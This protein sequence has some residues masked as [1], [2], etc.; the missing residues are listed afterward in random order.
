MGVMKSFFVA[1]RH[2]GGGILN[3]AL[4][5]SCMACG[6]ET[7]QAGL[8]CSAC[9]SKITFISDPCCDACGVPLTATG[10]A[11]R[12]LCTDCE[13]EH[14]V[15]RR[16]RGAFIYDDF[17]RRLILGLK[18]QDRT[19]NA[20]F[21]ATQMRRAG[22]ELLLNAD[23]IVPVPLHRS[24]LWHRR[25]NQAALLAKHL[26]R[27][28]RNLNFKADILKRARNTRSLASMP[29]R[30]RA[31]M[32]KEA[33]LVPTQHRQAVEGRRIVLIDDVLTTGATAGMCA[34]VLL[35]AGAASVD[36]LV[37]A[38]TSRRLPERNEDQ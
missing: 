37:A 31:E 21:L 8:L 4:P 12:G 29:A 9:F 19:E 28:Y 35:E 3:V 30:Q 20:L 32:M 33:I 18:Y 6:A 16:S 24:R 34:Q 5:P 25:Y 38:R 14:P 10:F 2:L 13:Q 26:A 1:L 36:V 22:A 7:A 11:Q 17:S 15:W 27:N 23:W